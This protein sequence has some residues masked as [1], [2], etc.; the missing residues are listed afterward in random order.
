MRSPRH[1]CRGWLP[2]SLEAHPQARGKCFLLRSLSR[3]LDF[4][5]CQPLCLK[6][7]TDMCGDRTVLIIAI[8][9]NVALQHS[10]YVYRGKNLAWTPPPPRLS[11]D[12][13]RS[14]EKHI[15]Q[16]LEAKRAS[17]RRSETRSPLG[18]TPAK[19]LSRRRLYFVRGCILPPANSTTVSVTSCDK[20]THGTLDFGCAAIASPSPCAS[21]PHKT[22]SLI[23]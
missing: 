6:F 4:H 15:R 14:L 8:N 17:T 9:S 22:A 19:P 1:F 13:L 16:P 18:L 12:L 20:S 10:M 2:L 7:T 21:T 23:L 5:P 11:T 3:L